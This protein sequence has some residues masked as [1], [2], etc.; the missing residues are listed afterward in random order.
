MELPRRLLLAAL[1][2]GSDCV[3]LER[4]VSPV[5]A[6]DGLVYERAALQD[7]LDKHGADQV[8]LS[9]A[10][11]APLLEEHS[12]S[13]FE[14]AAALAK[15]EAKHELLQKQLVE[16]L[17]PY[18]LAERFA[19]IARQRGM[20]SYTGLTAEQVRRLRAE[21]PQHGAARVPAV[22]G[23]RDLVRQDLRLMGDES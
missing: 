17:T 1:L 2:A 10:T 14:L 4:L 6:A 3:T 20:F 16:A 8:V 9:P 18:G 7:W 5:T 22:Q 21:D 12:R 11:G 13:D 23:R 15:M 19:H